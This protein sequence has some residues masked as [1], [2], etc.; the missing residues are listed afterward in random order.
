MPASK[1]ESDSTRSK[2]RHL[3]VAIVSHTHPSL[4]PG[5]GEVPAYTLYEGLTK[6]GHDALYV[7]VVPESVRR[8]A[9][10]KSEKERLLF[11][12]DDGFDPFYQLA[13]QNLGAQVEEVV[14]AHASRIVNFHHR[15]HTGLD[16]LRRVR[17]IP[18]VRTAFTFQDLYPLCAND[19]LM[20]TRSDAQICQNSS[21]EA[22]V[23]CFPTRTRYEFLQRRRLLLD[24][25]SSFD[26]FV[27][28]GDV[29][30]ERLCDWGLDRTRMHV[31]ENGLA[32]MPDRAALPPVPARADWVFGYFGVIRPHKG[33]ELLLDAAQRLKQAGV[34]NVRIRIHGEIVDPTE[35][36]G[37]KLRSAVASGVVQYVGAYD[38]P[39]VTARMRECDYVV[40]P[41]AGQEG[42][43]I[44]V[45][46]AF[47]A[48]RPVLCAGFG[49]MAEKVR[50]GDSG[51]HFVAGD[52]VDLMRC[53]LEAA[54]EPVHTRL[55]KGVP[56]PIDSSEMARRYLEVFQN[57]ARPKGPSSV[58]ETAG[59]VQAI[60]FG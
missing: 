38:N 30:A 16:A 50:A 59:E 37:E 11:C 34:E 17:A 18:G 40:A 35:A 25:L 51:L 31:I 3:R 27:S 1:T 42:S 20:V 29:L 56:A 39:G 6:L 55:M 26:H 48:H 9:F 36:L 58:V 44:V 41:G 53:I 32:R 52:S 19:G 2:G 28:P 8:K 23:G 24:V 15:P 60:T 13:A 14:R 10:R 12:R 54:D 43:A 46:E 5:R 21:P 22:C 45:Q 33:V 4:V 7:A 47:A 49:G 57:S